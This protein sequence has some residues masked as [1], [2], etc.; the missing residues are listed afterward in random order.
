MP[1]AAGKPRPLSEGEELMALHIRAERL[2]APERE[3]VFHPTR[4]WRFDFAWPAPYRI[5]V[6]CEGGIHSGGRHVR[7]SGFK[8]D[9]E[10]YN[11]AALL[12]WRVL[13]F[14]TEQVRDGTAIATLKRAFA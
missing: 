9:A 11:E 13:R 1:R 3:H 5:A 6:E 14:A 10:K 7:A 4:K 12:G 8:A 2:P